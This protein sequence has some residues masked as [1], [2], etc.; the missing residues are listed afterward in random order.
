[1]VTHGFSA[2]RFVAPRAAAGNR[3]KVPLPTHGWRLPCL[4][5]RGDPHG[6]CAKRET[7]EVRTRRC[8]PLFGLY[9]RFTD[10]D[11]RVS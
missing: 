2:R 9:V 10:D 4:S 1:M 5:L 6:G 8:L 11:G 7:G 3:G